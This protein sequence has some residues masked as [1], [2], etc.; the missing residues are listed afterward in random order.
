MEAVSAI[1]DSIDPVPIDTAEHERRELAQVRA[2]LQ[3]LGRR[4][5]EGEGQAMTDE[6]REQFRLWKGKVAEIRE[7]LKETAGV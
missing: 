6:E 7:R 5:I 2:N 3:A 1:P 4:L